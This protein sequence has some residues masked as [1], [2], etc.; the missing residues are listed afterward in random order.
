MRENDE[1]ASVLRDRI[2][3]ERANQ[4]QAKPAKKSTE[5]TLKATGKRERKKAQPPETPES[6]NSELIQLKLAGIE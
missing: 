3:E 1:P 2:R 5:K 4:P 6:D